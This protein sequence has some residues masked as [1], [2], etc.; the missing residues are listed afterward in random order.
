MIYKLPP[1]SYSYDALEPYIDALTMEIHY[2][3][4]HQTYIDNLNAAL[5]K[6]PEIEATDLNKLLSNLNEL[7][8]DIRT[9]VRDNGGGNL[10]H[11]MFW[12]LMKP[13]G[14]GNPKGMVAQGIDKHFGSFTA[15]QD[16]FNNAVKTRF[17]S[18]WAWL[19]V[20][21]SGKLVISSTA[22][23]DSPISD[24]LQPIMG[25]DVWEHA[26][27]LKYHN[28]RPDYINAWW[29]VID[30]DRIEENLRHIHGR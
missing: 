6:H 18:G 20:D 23:Q 30:W 21:K 2:T 22:N 16:Q 10:N 5:A 24:G 3:K 17:G 1:L 26:Y 4:H 14:G 27:Y 29:H 15:F 19:S 7:P 8:E 12:T 11:T 25:L 28:R 9:A 13:Q